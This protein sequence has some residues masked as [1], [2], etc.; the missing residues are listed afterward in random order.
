MVRHTHVAR[1]DHDDWP[2]SRV[3]TPIG[4]KQNSQGFKV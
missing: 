1:D 3:M 2:F 4:Y